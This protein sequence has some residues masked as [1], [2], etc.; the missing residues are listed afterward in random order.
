VPIEKVAA[1]AGYRRTIRIRT[2]SELDHALAGFFAEPGPAMLLVE[3]ERGN[4]PGI[5]RVEPAPAE[6]TARFRRSAIS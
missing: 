6:L 1:A 4:Q 5:G 2:A 3:V